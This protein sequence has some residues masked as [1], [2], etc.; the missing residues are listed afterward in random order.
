MGYK[1][2]K[3]NIGRLFELLD[4]ISPEFWKI[5]T[6]NGYEEPSLLVRLRNAYEKIE[7]TNDSDYNDFNK[8][9]ATELNRKVRKICFATWRLKDSEAIASDDMA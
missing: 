9:T 4:M 7:S 5:V 6:S 2:N 8:D 3:T 1:Q